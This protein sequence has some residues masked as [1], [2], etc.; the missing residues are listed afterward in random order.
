MRLGGLGQCEGGGNGCNPSCGSCDPP[1]SPPTGGYQ[2]QNHIQCVARPFCPQVSLLSVL[3]APFFLPLFTLS[4][5]SIHAIQSHSLCRQPLPIAQG[6]DG[7]CHVETH[8]W[9]AMT[10]EFKD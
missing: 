3:L 7:Q 9:V 4:S 10:A 6:L 8:R 2:W 5:N 1:L